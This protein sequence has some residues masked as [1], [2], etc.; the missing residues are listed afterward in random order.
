M[1]PSSHRSAVAVSLSLLLSAAG[2]A[3]PSA[4]PRANA[5]AYRVV[6]HA[7]RAADKLPLA[8]VVSPPVRVGAGEVR[9]R[10]DQR[11]PSENRPAFPEFRARLEP[12]RGGHGLVELVTRASVREEYRTKK[13]KRKV[14]KRYIG[15]LLPIRPGETLGVNGPGDPVTVEVR[16]ESG[17]SGVDDKN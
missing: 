11:E 15:A 7:R 13:G 16:I 8:G 2:C 17:G 12:M 5:P 10:T 3:G 14:S 4:T 9:V 1:R 6:W